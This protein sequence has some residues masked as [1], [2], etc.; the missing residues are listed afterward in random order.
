MFYSIPMS[1]CIAS[2]SVPGLPC[3]YALRTRS[4]LHEVLPSPNAPNRY[5]SSID[6]LGI[7][8]HWASLGIGLDFALWIEAPFFYMEQYNS[9]T[10]AYLVPIALF[11]HLARRIP[12]SF[13]PEIRTPSSDC[14]QE[15]PTIARNNT[16]RQHDMQY[17]F[18]NLVFLQSTGRCGSTLLSKILDTFASYVLR[19]QQPTNPIDVD[20]LIVSVARPRCLSLS[21]PDV[22][23]NLLKYTQP[24]HD[25]YLQACVKFLFKP[26]SSSVSATTLV[27]KTRGE[28]VAQSRQLARCFPNARI[29]F[30]YRN[31]I[32]TI[33]SF[34]AAF[35]DSPLVTYG[36]ADRCLLSTVKFGCCDIDVVCHYATDC[37]NSNCATSFYE[38]RCLAT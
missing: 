29:L 35:A 28:S 32:R 34:H 37:S 16:T 25:E 10:E 11:L 8:G 4:I 9:A 22:F 30:L 1:R 14:G 3:L 36:D 5:N 27:I 20:V 6:T 26:T 13:S 17:P 33:Q 23:T 2:M 24:E 7:V 12:S 19:P 21:E 18:N 31:G 15:S 38:T